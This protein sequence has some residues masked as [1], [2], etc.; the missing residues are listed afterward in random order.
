MNYNGFMF[1]S[2]DPL[3]VLMA[4]ALLLPIVTDAVVS[5]D[6]SSRY[7]AVASFILAAVAG[8]AASTSEVDWTAVGDWTSA[9]WELIGTYISAAVV[10]KET[11]LL[12]LHKPLAAGTEK[13]TILAA[14]PDRG[15]GA[16][17]DA[18]V[19]AASVAANIDEGD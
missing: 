4:S 1:D 9:D 16:P 5:W 8:L 3:V 12:S 11:G 19:A 7:K 17:A 14:F 13:P 18:S 10:G 15:L 6:A 2:I